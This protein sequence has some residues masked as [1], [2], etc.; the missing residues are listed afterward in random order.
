MLK[1]NKMNTTVKVQA[2]VD[3]LFESYDCSK[4]L[5]KSCAHSLNSN[6]ACKMLQYNNF[7]E[8]KCIGLL[9]IFQHFFIILFFEGGGGI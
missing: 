8:K 5:S 1:I 4:Y 7:P 3:N 6:S 2:N 9:P